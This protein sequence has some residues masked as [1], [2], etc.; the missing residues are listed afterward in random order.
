MCET[1]D[2]RGEVNMQIAIVSR[3]GSVL[4]AYKRF[5]EGQGVTLIHALSIAELYRTLPETSI[6][7]FM[8]EIHMAVKAADTEKD[9]LHT[10]AGI[11]PNIKTNWSPADGFRAL[12]HGAGKSGEENLSAFVRDCR[13]FKPR[14]L[15]KDKRHEKKCNVLFWPGGV[16]AETAQRAFTLDI[17]L[18]GLFVCTCDPPPA[19]SIVWVTL[20]EVDARPFQV[21][22]KWMLEWGVAMRIP[23]FGGSF[24]ETEDDLKAT[25]EAFLADNRR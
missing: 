17:S 25:L 8:I 22:V 13:N 14:A 19:G 4:D 6:S 5:F 12:H 3:S 15:R 20:Q 2:H 21:L 11:F 16:S 7:G 1:R 9:L 10:L 18:G 24:I 23:G